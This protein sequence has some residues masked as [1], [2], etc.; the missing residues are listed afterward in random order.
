MP[1]KAIIT[2]NKDVTAKA[3]T[4]AVKAAGYSATVKAK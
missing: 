3:L 2:A 1:N 4:D